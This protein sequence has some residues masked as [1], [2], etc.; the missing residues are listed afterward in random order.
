MGKYVT[1]EQKNKSN[2]FAVVI[3]NCYKN[4]LMTVKQII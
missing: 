2:F 3:L 4:C 1:F